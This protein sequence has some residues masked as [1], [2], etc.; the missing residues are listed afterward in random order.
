MR[1]LEFLLS[2]LPV[3]S[4][5]SPSIFLLFLP[6]VILYHVQITKPMILRTLPV[7]ASLPVGTVTVHMP[8]LMLQS[9]PG[10][11]GPVDWEWGPRPINIAVPS[12]AEQ[13][14]VDHIF[15]DTDVQDSS[16][17]RWRG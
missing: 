16:K 7:L 17:K 2:R 1:S 10:W 15:T 5:P 12:V 4:D 9:G 6:R 13:M 8:Y 3:P 11:I 14:F